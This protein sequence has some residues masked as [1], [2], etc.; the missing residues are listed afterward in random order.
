MAK[1]IAVTNQKGGV[2]KTTT[3][4]NLASALGHMNRRVLLVDLD[5]QGNTTSAVGI[6]KPKVEKSVYDVIMHLCDAKDALIETKFKNLIIMP[7]SIDLAGVDL[8]LASVETGRE[9]M[10]K[11]QID[12]VR[13]YFDFIIIDCPPSLGVLNTNALSAADSVII[14]VQS[15]FFALEGLTQLLMTVRLVQKNFNAGLKIEGVLLTMFDARN[16]LSLEV[17]QEV[18]KYFKEKVYK[19]IINR[20][21]RLSEAPG[22][23]MPICE[24]DKGSTGCKD[25]TS[26]A[27]E[28]DKANAKNKKQNK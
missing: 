28:V 23:G 18:R 21:V 9:K 12:K 24:Y 17:A 20:N 15:E 3:S 5:P 8:Q 22:N 19:T 11:T 10:L 1:V 13:S 4:V 26:L 16:N 25:Y 14:P 6:D 7:A 2:G 27:K